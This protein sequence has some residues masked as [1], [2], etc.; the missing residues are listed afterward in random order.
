MTYRYMNINIMGIYIEYNAL[1][2][3]DDIMIYVTPVL[4]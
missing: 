2:F 1:R 4:A 3:K